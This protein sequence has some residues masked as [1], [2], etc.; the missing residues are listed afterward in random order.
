MA[1]QRRPLDPR[2]AAARA[3]QK[4]LAGESLNQCLPPLVASVAERERG[5]LQQLS[6]G[7]LRLY[8]R[9]QALLG[10]LLDKPLRAKD[11][12][13][14]ALLLIGLYQLAET[15]IPDHA[16][17]STTVAATATLG[18]GWARGL[19]NGVLRRYAR[20]AD[21]LEQALD[22][23]SAAA[24][25]AWLYDEIRQQWPAR[26]ASVLEAN[27]SQPPMTLRID[28]SRLSRDEYLAQLQAA[29]LGG[30][31]GPLSAAAVYLEQATDVGQLPGFAEGLVSVQDEA[32]QLA[33]PLLD[34]RPGDRVLDAC[35]APGGKTG[36]I[37][38]CS[39]GLSLAAMDIDP[40]RLERVAANL[41]RL[42]RAAELLVGDG[43]SPPAALA[44]RRFD[45]ILV[46][47]PCSATG[48]IRRHP[49]IKV[50]RRPDDP[51]GFASQQLAILEGLWPLLAPGGSLLYV[52]CS[53]LA[54][55]N[56]DL[57]ASFLSAHPQARAEPIP[58]PWG[59][60]TDLG[61]Q[62]LPE[63]GGADGLYFALLRSAA[64]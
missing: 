39:P 20:E 13:V 57:V 36:H 33:A 46:D 63:P 6:Y 9:L 45:R 35:A 27:N 59:C 44:A 38:E 5:L 11:A 21:T 18:K 30:R 47:A 15:R 41:Q 51:A 52:T 23:A 48:V 14:H 26:F 19:C 64:P 32:A 60:A 53:I 25:P 2:V 54:Q 28:L 34:C 12:D 4:V 29:G 37:L 1:Q 31:P 42:Q 17:V 7:C 24:H 10:Q 56:D 58:Q 50:L 22:P 43:A 16:A 55:E 3:V 40:T 8:P 62:L 61:R 49:D